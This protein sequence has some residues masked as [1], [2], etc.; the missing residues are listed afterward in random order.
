MT[1]KIYRAVPSAYA[2]LCGLT[3]IPAF[4]WCYAFV[5]GRPIQLQPILMVLF[6]VGVIAF[7]LSR[8]R[9]TI[10]NSSIS[11]SS[12]FQGN[13]SIPRTDIQSIGFVIAKSPTSPLVTAEVKRKDG[14]SITINVK[15]F[16]KEAVKELMAMK[17]MA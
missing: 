12:L 6:V 4:V 9:L 15:V 16:S 7:W 17:G 1:E 11:Y 13:V 8:F 10:K 3:S 2:I 5:Q 14:T